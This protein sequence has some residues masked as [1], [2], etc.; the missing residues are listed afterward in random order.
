M[1]IRKLPPATSL[2][3]STSGKTADR[4]AAEFPEIAHHF[5]ISS[6]VAHQFGISY[7]P[8]ALDNINTYVRRK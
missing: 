2:S 7:R 3:T 8:D 4:K 5:G 6:E 1:T